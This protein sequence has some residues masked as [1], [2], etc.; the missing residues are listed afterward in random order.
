VNDRRAGRAVHHHHFEQVPG[1]VGSEHKPAHRVIANLLD[2]DSVV[3]G[4]ADIFARDAVAHG[5]AENLHQRIVLRNCR[6]AAQGRP[7]IYVLPY[8]LG[9]PASK[10]PVPQDAATA[11]RILIGG[12]AQD[13]HI[14]AIVSRLS[15]LHPRNDTFPGEVFL[16][17][18]ADALDQCGASRADPVA[19]EGIADRFLPECTFRGRDKRKLRFAVL[20]VAALHGGAEPDLLDEVVWWQTDDFWQYALFAAIA[21]IRAAADRAG[22]PVRQVCQ[23]LLQHE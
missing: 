22:V 16:R 18:G 5:R 8:G 19:L 1:P 23:E 14:F 2:G 9:M 10:R 21:Y 13:A 7:V 12:L 11:R 20:A 17:L 15:P 3:N 6:A 4:V